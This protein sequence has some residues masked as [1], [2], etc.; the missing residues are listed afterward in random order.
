MKSG[1]Q[2]FYYAIKEHPEVSLAVLYQC[3]KTDAGKDIRFFNKTQIES[4]LPYES[5]FREN[6]VKIDISPSYSQDYLLTSKNI[7]EYNPNAK[8]IIVVR[9]PVERAIS[10]YKYEICSPAKAK[11]N[12]KFPKLPDFQTAF[13]NDFRNIRKNGMIGNCINSYLNFFPRQN[14]LIIRFEDFAKHNLR[15]LITVLE[16]MKIN[17]DFRPKVLMAD[18]WNRIKQKYYGNEQKKQAIELP[19]IDFVTEYYQSQNRILKRI[20]YDELSCL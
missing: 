6:G 8:F 4:Y 9:D 1:T 20:Q 19:N 11:R 13:T 17:T 14:F 3:Y 16:F 7:Y 5:L 10:Q 2:W 15:F 12:K 18:Y